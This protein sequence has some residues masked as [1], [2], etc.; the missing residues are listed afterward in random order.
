MIHYDNRTNIIMNYYDTLWYIMIHYD[1]LW[2][3]MIHY[4]W[5]WFIMNDYGSLWMIMIHYEWLWFIMND[6]DSLWF[7]DCLWIIMYVRLPLYCETLLKASKSSELTWSVHMLDKQWAVMIHVG[8]WWASYRSMN[9]I[10]CQLTRFS[11]ESL[12]NYFLSMD[13]AARVVGLLCAIDPIWVN[14]CYNTFHSDKSVCILYFAKSK[15]NWFPK[16]THTI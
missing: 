5:L 3:I 14:P 8:K 4:E 12:K 10:P 15:S 9:I 7:C 2:F 11:P 13:T 6:Y 16:L 1:S